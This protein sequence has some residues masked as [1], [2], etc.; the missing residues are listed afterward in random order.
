MME[1]VKSKYICIKCLLIRHYIIL[2]SFDSKRG[3][4]LHE[5][6]N[7]YEERKRT[8]NFVC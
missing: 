4:K 8:E 1:L 2:F 3:T 5:D 7:K 6:G